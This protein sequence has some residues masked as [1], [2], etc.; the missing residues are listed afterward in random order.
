MTELFS[1]KN[2]SQAQFVIAVSFF[3]LTILSASVL[4]DPPI[5]LQAQVPALLKMIDER[6]KLIEQRLNGVSAPEIQSSEQQ[7]ATSIPR[8]PFSLSPQL[9]QDLSTNRS[10]GVS[11]FQQQN[12]GVMPRLKL[13]GIVRDEATNESFALL[14]VGGQ[15]VHLVRV[16]DEISFNPADPKQVIKIMKIAPSN[17]I[18]EVG[19]L[20][21]L[22]LVR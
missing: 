6:K 12:S 22:I 17:L 11:Q 9:L 19:T 18:V 5:S 20:G 7:K 2:E 4:A 16:G 1:G 15:D 13:K 21:D 8:D 3:I 14:D 10:T